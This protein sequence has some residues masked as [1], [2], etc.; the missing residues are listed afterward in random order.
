MRVHSLFS[1]HG[2]VIEEVIEAAMNENVGIQIDS[3]MLDER[4]QAHHIGAMCHVIE[5]SSKN[6]AWCFDPDWSD[7]FTTQL[8]PRTLG[9]MLVMEKR[10]WG[11]IRSTALFR[12]T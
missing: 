11:A 10:V 3:A 1:Q 2:L 6:L 8:P 12:Q 5:R 9:F 7:Q 4:L